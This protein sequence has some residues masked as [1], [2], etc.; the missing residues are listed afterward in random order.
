MLITKMLISKMLVTKMF[1]TQNIFTLNIYL[2]LLSF[3][4]VQCEKVNGLYLK[5]HSVFLNFGDK[6]LSKLNQTLLENSLLKSKVDVLG[7]IF[8][9]NIDVIKTNSVMDLVFLIDASS[10]VGEDNFQSELKFVKK[11]LSD[12]TVDYNHSRVAIITF[13]SSNNVVSSFKYLESNFKIKKSHL[14]DSNL[15]K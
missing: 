10:S 5:E 2:L 8:K 7:D 1:K 13:G 12:V 4:K 15:K 3:A 9:R 6:K 14:R 11:F